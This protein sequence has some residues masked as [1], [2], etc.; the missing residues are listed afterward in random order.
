MDYMEL[1][2]DAPNSVLE[3]YS[4]NKIRFYSERDLSGHLFY[5]CK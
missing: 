1:F 5:E 2:N 4:E 3:V